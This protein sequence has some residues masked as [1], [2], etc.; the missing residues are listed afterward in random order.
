MTI[1][2]DP[3]GGGTIQPADV[4]YTE[5]E[6][7]AATTQLVW[8]RF[9]QDGDEFVARITA[10]MAAT[11]VFNTLRLPPANQVSAGLDV[12]FSNR[13]AETIFIQD[14]DGT[15]VVQVDAG[16]EQY[17]Y[18]T[19]NSGAAGTWRS[20]L[21]G[22]GTS[23][24]DA[25][26]LAGAGLIA[27]VGLLDANWPAL[28]TSADL[29]ISETD[30]GTVVNWTS[31]AG[32]ISLPAPGD[33]GVGFIFGLRNQGT[34]V[35]TV[36][37][38]D[39]LIDGESTLDFNPQESAFVTCGNSGWYT[40]GR[41]RNA[42]FNFTLLIKS[43]TGGVTTLTA[44]EASNVVQQYVGAL[45]SNATI[46]LPPVVQVY[47]IANF[48]SGS[49]TVTFEVAGGAG[50]SVAIP[51]GQAAI[52]FC[53][54]VDVINNSTTAAGLL[55]LTLDPGSAGAPSLSFTG[56]SGT[57]V[58]RPVAG[59]VGVAG[60]GAEALR[61]TSDGTSV[62]YAEISGGATGAPVTLNARGSNTNVG[63]TATTKGSGAFAITAPTL[64]L[65]AASV[66]W[67]APTHSS[68]HTFSGA[69]TVNGALTIGALGSLT[70]NPTSVTW[71]AGTTTHSG[72]AHQFS[73]NMSVAGT[74][75]CQSAVTFTSSL[76]VT[77]NVTIGNAGSDTLTVHPTA[78]TWVNNPTHSGNHTFSGNLVVAGNTTLGNSDADSLTVNASTLAF[79]AASS[80]ITAPS[81]FGLTAASIDLVGN[82][83]VAAG[84]AVVVATNL[85]LTA[86]VAL[87]VDTPLATFFGDVTIIGTL[88]T[89]ASLGFTNLTVTGNTVLGT[90]SA[91]TLTLRATTTLG[92]GADLVLDAS[93]TPTSTL[94]VGFRG[95]PQNSRSTAYT[96]V[97]SD[98]GRHVLHPSSDATARVFTIDSNANVP[99]PIGTA[100]TFINQNGAGV[101]T[102][103][104][105]SDTMRLAGA[106]TT[107]SRTLAANGIATAIKIATTEWIISG[108]GLA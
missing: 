36:D 81:G 33:A 5:L 11:G 101:V 62:N 52:L 104:I 15:E 59:S 32:T 106:G 55:A 35:L 91:N 17:V 80:F 14:Y 69:V 54:G 24:V 97:G 8:P 47:F 21:F 93:L 42:N 49:Y 68:N 65:S 78:V 2:T 100:I 28:D 12:L 48:T 40:V 82:F 23:V 39:D 60:L 64:V 85:N 107:G 16:E 22:A 90:N 77:G 31:G 57:G 37:A 13:T 70:V 56:D 87:D 61:V 50:A 53:D 18:L 103:A 9:A 95:I 98:A 108:T 63:I 58:F 34:G 44:A 6:L 75:S 84:T 92:S 94:S 19:D 83:S 74:L 72:A 96:T 10:I 1:Y 67:S 88:T 66:T 105:T 51:T 4:S 27:N 43:I 99:Y 3:F 7:V 79:Q 29:E 73:G 30:R 45:V 25:A 38:G 71:N 76:L 41:G 89:S 46:E 20:V 102:I 86:A 26:Q